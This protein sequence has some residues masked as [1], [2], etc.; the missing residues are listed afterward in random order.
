MST[1]P[2]PVAGPRETR[3]ALRRLFRGRAGALCLAAAV[4]LLAALAGLALPAALGGIVDAV[5]GGDPA[6][7]LPLVLVIAGVGLANAGL[8]GLGRALVAR[9]G[10]RVLAELRGL[11]VTRLI[12]LPATV[13]ER[14]GRGDLVSRAS[15]DTR[16]VGDVVSN[17][18]PSFASAGFTVVVTLV[19]LGALDWR[20]ALAALAAVPVQLLALRA[21]LKRAR[22]V[23]RAARAAEGERAQRILESVDAADTV[24]AMG[25]SAERER[26]VDEA[27]MRSVELER[28]AARISVGFWNQLN[29]AEFLGLAAVLGAG[30]LLVGADLA[31]VGAATTA[32][33]YFHALFGP[34]GQVLGSVDELQKAAAGLARLVGVL[35]LPERGSRPA[36]SRGGAAGLELDRVG[37]AYDGATALDGVSFAVAPGETV[38]LVGASGAGKSTVA[39]LVLGALEPERGRVLLDGLDVGAAT[40]ETRLPR[41]GLAGQEPH[42]FAGPLGD[43]LRLARPGAAEPELRAALDAVGALGWVDRLPEGLGTVVGAGGHR[44]TIVESQQLALARLLL[45]D[46][47]ILVLDEATAAA[48]GD[49]DHLLDRAIARVAAGRTTVTIAHRLDQAARADRV[50]VLDRGAVVEEGA[51]AELVAADGVYGRLWAAWTAGRSGEPRTSR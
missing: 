46:P 42:V 2:L 45:H 15:T 36:P 29:L 47:A 24:R 8:T 14:A 11:V 27:A 13:V 32:A 16:I 22:P 31:T 4:L 30:F 7:L 41:I 34:V 37:F 12:R 40:A 28:R 19:G 39:A 51:H 44:L 9:L 6:A 50:I 38:A 1:T 21:Y 48:G 20:F 5:L 43:D 3:R 49:G 18:V 25:V 17:I 23:Y 10:E 33:L 26:V 35:E